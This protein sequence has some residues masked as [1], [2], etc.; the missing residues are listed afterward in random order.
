ML[1][2]LFSYAICLRISLMNSV[3]YDGLTSENILSC[4]AKGI[5]IA[6]PL[7]VIFG[8]FVLWIHHAPAHLL[9]ASTL[10]CL[11]LGRSSRAGLYTLLPR[12]DTSQMK[13]S[14]QQRSHEGR[15]QFAAA[16]S[17]LHFR[18]IGRQLPEFLQRPISSTKL[19]ISILSFVQTLAPSEITIH[20]STI[21][22]CGDSMS[23]AS[24]Q[25]KTPLHT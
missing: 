19:K 18:K 25:S 9:L 22:P 5:S 14:K 11:P 17:V 20:A 16:N 3:L 13:S 7:V 12:S 21:I 23:V 24:T 2:M 4:C 6:S 8:T 15:F 10:K 1:F